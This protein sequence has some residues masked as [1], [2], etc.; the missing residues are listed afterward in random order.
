MRHNLID[1]LKIAANEIDDTG[2]AELRGLL[3][4]AAMEVER[5]KERITRLCV[6]AAIIIDENNQ[7]P[8]NRFSVIQLA[9]AAS[10]AKD[11]APE[12]QDASDAVH[13]LRAE[14]DRVRQAVTG[15]YLALDKRQHGGAAQNQ[16][17]S[18]IER[19]LGMNWEQ[20]VALKQE[21]KA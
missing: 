11:E 2:D 21:Q 6:A 4:E 19:A 14:V 9:G 15:Y 1:R 3:N 5:L 20:G 16:A 8:D 12:A 13:R 17:F 7:H 10:R 18:E